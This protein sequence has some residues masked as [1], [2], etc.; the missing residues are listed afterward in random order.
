MKRALGIT[1][2]ALLV[3]L[4]PAGCVMSL[5]LVGG[6]IAAATTDPRCLSE[7]TS[8]PAVCTP[9]AIGPS[10][11]GAPIPIDPGS[12]PAPDPAAAS[13][14][15]AAIEA[16]DRH[17][18]YIAEGNGPVDFDCSGLTAFAWRA[19]GVGLVDYSFTQWNQ[20]QRI[21]RSALAP[22]DLVFWF[23]GDVHHVAIVVAVNGAHVQIAE[24]ANPDVGVRIRDFGDAWDQ[25][26]L[27]GFGRV[28]R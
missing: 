7:A 24:A 8:D 14:V 10:L 20:T 11:F 12:I 17:G 21:P 26:Y 1:S 15:Q 2:V 16:V 13:A 27:T 19:A 28:T 18:R 23:G 6:S 3:C 4:A 25:T 9:G 22:G 5:A